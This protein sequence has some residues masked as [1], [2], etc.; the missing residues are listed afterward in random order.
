MRHPSAEVSPAIRLS[1]NTAKLFVL[2]VRQ[3]ASGSADEAFPVEFEL[4][5]EST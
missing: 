3:L 4:L 1:L 5:S 2:N